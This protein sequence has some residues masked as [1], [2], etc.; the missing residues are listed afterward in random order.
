[1]R[2]SRAGSS[3]TRCGFSPRQ[4]VLSLPQEIVCLDDSVTA[5]D[6]RGKSI[7]PAAWSG[8]ADTLERT[9]VRSIVTKIEES[10]L[11]SRKA[12]SKV[13]FEE[14][15]TMCFRRRGLSSSTT[16][17]AGEGAAAAWLAEKLQR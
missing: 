16:V 8:I 14:I 12:V 10:N 11:P 13:G 3:T 1:V 17:E 6:Y 15:A 9:G 7:A 4:G 5:E 2:R